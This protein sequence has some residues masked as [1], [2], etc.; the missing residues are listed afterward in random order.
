ME[1]F[2]GCD[3]CHPTGAGFR[4]APRASMDE[5]ARLTSHHHDC[6]VLDMVL[7]YARSQTGE[8]PAII[9]LG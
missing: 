2:S 5:N 9:G 6:V 4:R 8:N 1:A 7:K 3:L